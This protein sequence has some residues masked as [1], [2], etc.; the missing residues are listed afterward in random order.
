MT[1]RSLRRRLAVALLL[2]MLLVLVLDAV[3]VY[4]RAL[5]GA[6]TGFDRTLYAS[7]RSILDGISLRRGEL[8]VALPHEALE[9]FDD[10]AAVRVFYRI[11]DERGLLL[12][13]YGDLPHP[14]GPAP[15]LYQPRYYDA[16]YH[17]ERL[18][19]IAMRQPVHA[20]AAMPSRVV[21]VIVG[22]SGEL[23]RAFAR[24]MLLDA[25]WR[26]GLLMALMTAIV[27]AALRRGLAPL[28]L[29]TREVRGRGEDDL[30]PFP[31]QQRPEELMPLVAALNQY[32]ERLRRMLKARQRFFTDAAHQLK[33]PLAV[34]TAQ[35]ELA[36]REPDSRSM[37]GRLG[38]MRR[39]LEDA[40]HGV[41]QL[42]KLARLEQDATGPLP[43]T[44]LDLSAA[45]RQC[46]LDWVALARRQGVDLGLGDCASL[47]VR[48]HP[49]LLQDMVGNLIDNAIRYAGPG[50]AITLSVERDAEC[51]VIVVV[52]NGPGIP[53]AERELV[54]SRFHRG[55]TAQG[56]GSGLGLAIVAEVAARHQ[57]QVQLDDSPGGGLTVRI[58]LP[59]AAPW[60]VLT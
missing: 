26:Q 30:A 2:P 33:T 18:R 27:L 36:E 57:A 16:D 15:E 42:L 6:Y 49:S 25:L 45:L 41:G 12:T 47:L 14:E 24:S 53:P 50:S 7:A 21:W 29:L 22:E 23:R 9:Y 3:I 28:W 17:G 38:T 48:S 5:E 4:H 46:A 37:R 39:S 59:L 13:G 55:S 32:L 40:S 51:A 1:P 8:H 43:L 20:V 54:F 56:D 31:T 11:S 58:A 52:D 34:L 60:P 10:S 35:A 19:L 44:V